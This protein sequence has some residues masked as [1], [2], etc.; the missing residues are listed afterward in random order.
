MD[1][2]FMNGFCWG[3]IA[4]LIVVIGL[5]WLVGSGKDRLCALQGWKGEACQCRKLLMSDEPKQ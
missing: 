2:D 5:A 1:D 4:A 3:F